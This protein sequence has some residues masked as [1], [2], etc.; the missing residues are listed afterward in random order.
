MM[1]PR[2]GSGHDNQKGFTLLEL[3]IA[4][5]IAALITA[6]ITMAIMQILTI[7]HRAS[8]HMIAVRQVQQAGKEVSKDALQAQPSKIDDEPP[9]AF[10]VLNW[11]DSQSRNNTVV[12]TL[13]DMPSTSG[14]KKL[15]RTHTINGTMEWTAIPIVAEYIDPDPAKT[16]CVWAGGILT[17]TVT[18][19]VGTQSETRVYE[20]EPRP[21]Q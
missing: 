11:T 3:I 19:T 18:A 15:Q 16:S 13:Q 7:N 10:L 8:N 9:G 17:F 5:A 4:I 12:Y 14:L 6:G 20:I 21:T 1:F 2:L